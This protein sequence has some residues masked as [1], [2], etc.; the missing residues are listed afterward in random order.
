MGN[1]EQLRAN[2]GLFVLY[3]TRVIG[4]FC[5]RFGNLSHV[6]LPQENWF[7]P[8]IFFW[9]ITGPFPSPRK[10]RWATSNNCELTPASLFYTKR[11][12][13]LIFVLALVTWVMFPC[14]RKNGF[15]LLFFFRLIIGS[16]PSPRKYRWATSYNSE[17]TPVSLFFKN[18]ALSALLV[19]AL[20][21]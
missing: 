8:C 19:L 6:S 15:S 10:Y 7:F 11:A 14:L 13:S 3:K 16:F 20:V 4:A 9:L 1:F 17:L 21:T 5:S 18:H 2:T 12:L